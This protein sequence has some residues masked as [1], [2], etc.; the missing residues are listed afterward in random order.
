VEGEYLLLTWRIVKD[1]NGKLLFIEAEP[2]EG[3]SPSVVNWQQAAYKF[4]TSVLS[5]TLADQRTKF[6]RRVFFNYIG[7]ALDGEYW[8][9][10]V[11]F[12]PVLPDD[13]EP[14][15]IC[16]ERVISF[17]LLVDAIDDMDASSLAGEVARRY[18]ARL[19]LLL[20]LGLY[21]SL[22]EQRWVTQSPDGVRPVCCT[23]QGLFFHYSGPRLT[24]LPKKGSICPLGKYSGSLA[25][26]RVIGELLSLPPETRK[27]LR[28]IDVANP[29]I[30]DAFDRGARLHQ[31]AAVVGLQYPSVGLAYRVAALEAISQSDPS[32]N[33][34][35]DFVR[36]HVNRSDVDMLLDYL[37][38]KVRSAHFHGGE[39]PLGEFGTRRFFDPLIDIEEMGR[40]EFHRKCFSLIREA[41]AN[42][43]LSLLPA[44]D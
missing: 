9:P 11:R 35:S 12:A 44:A 24:E 5:S 30:T 37:Y 8:L 42:W 2:A 1:N 33:G 4:L 40:S 15:L 22:D 28:A 10:G 21:K 18:A 25:G 39:F 14:Y 7:V 29:I 38:P 17:D 31:V 32:C 26:Y 6:F 16:A 43:L 23:R 41:I 19:S 34:F 20:D 13:E 36:K 27:I 3:R